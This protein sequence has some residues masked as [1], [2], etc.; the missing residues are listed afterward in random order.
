MTGGYPQSYPYGR[1]FLNYTSVANLKS[2]RVVSALVFRL[3][4]ISSIVDFGCAQGAWLSA[5]RQLG[6]D[7]VLGLDGDYV[8]RNGLVIPEEKFFAADISEK[9][10]LGRK[11]DLVQSVEV[12]EH[13]L[14]TKS[15]QFVDN[16]SA[17]GEFILF[18]AA[19]PGQG[20]EHHINERPYA[21]W[22]DLFYTRGFTMYD[23]VRPWIATDTSVQYWYRYNIFLFVHER[24]TAELPAEIVATQISKNVPVPDVAP[25]LF[26]LRKSI[27]RHL[28]QTLIDGI[29]R[30][31]SRLG[32]RI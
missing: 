24:R 22:R 15:E 7:D 3:L 2:A 10:D 32:S 5:W 16:L 25:P 12:A 6:V 28:P 14:P 9:I 11:F 8:E 31:K 18:S 4:P 27:V 17:H 26:K 21:Y 1:T 23:P 20:G 30:A 13:L 19:P 29:A